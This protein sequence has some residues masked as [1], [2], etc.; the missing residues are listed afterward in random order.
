[1]TFGLEHANYMYSFPEWQLTFFAPCKLS[2]KKLKCSDSSDSDSVAFMTLLTTPFFLFLL[3][4]EC[5][6]DSAYDSASVASEN[7]P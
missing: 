5:S 7:W 4:H 6:Y 3:G 2:R 1:M